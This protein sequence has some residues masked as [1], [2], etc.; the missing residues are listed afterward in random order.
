MI[1]ETPPVSPASEEDPELN[2]RA[3]ENEEQPVQDHQNYNLLIDN[4][5]LQPE[6]GDIA[7][8][9][10]VQAVNLQEARQN[11]MGIDSESD[12]D[13]VASEAP[14]Q[15]IVLESEYST[16]E[17][18]EGPDHDLDNNDLLYEGSGISVAAAMLAILTFF[19]PA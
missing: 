4:G 7:G 10:A 12:H 3:E 15:N 17:D 11:A 6:N 14:I 16:D 2:N 13:S 9:A 1:E 19:Y 18:T 8:Q 5:A